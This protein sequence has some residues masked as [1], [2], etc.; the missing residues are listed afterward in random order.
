M[1]TYD[2]DIYERW[3]SILR[4]ISKEDLEGRQCTITYLRCLLGLDDESVRKIQEEIETGEIVLFKSRQDKGIIDMS[5]QAMGIKQE[6]VLKDE[7]IKV[8]NKRNQSK[9]FQTWDDIASYYNIGLEVYQCLHGCCETW[10]REKL[11]IG[12]TTPKFPQATIRYVE[13]IISGKEGTSIKVLL[14]LE[15]HIG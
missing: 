1:V 12:K 14:S 3:I 6:R 5:Q 10:L 9:K 8:F 13:W 2:D 4:S 11:Q 15:S 7:L